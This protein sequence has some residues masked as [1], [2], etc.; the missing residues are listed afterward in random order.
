MVSGDLKVDY[1][2]RHLLDLSFRA[3][4]MLRTRNNK[5]IGERETISQPMDAKHKPKNYSPGGLL[6]ISISCTIGMPTV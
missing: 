1:V 6:F 4:S 3:R 2:S 5:S